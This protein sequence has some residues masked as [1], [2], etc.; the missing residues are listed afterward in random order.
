MQSFNLCFAKIKSI[1]IPTLARGGGGSVPVF[2]A[3]VESSCFVRRKKFSLA[4]G[5][6]GPVP[7]F[8]APV[9]S[10][11]LQKTEKNLKS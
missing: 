3:L 5:G 2:D 10:S 9:E 7:I 6:G 4:G 1:F 11:F 8:H